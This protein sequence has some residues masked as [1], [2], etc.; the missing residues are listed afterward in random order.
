M[1]LNKA[2]TPSHSPSRWIRLALLAVLPLAL[3]LLV[4]PMLSCAATDQPSP[5]RPLGL[6]TWNPEVFQPASR[7]L[8]RTFEEKGRLIDEV[9]VPGRPPKD[10]KAPVVT[11][12]K[13]I[14]AMGVSALSFVPA[15]DWCY[16][17][18]AT[19]AA[20]LAGYYDNHGFPNMYNGPTNGG[21]CPMNNS[22]WGFG[23]CPLS[24]THMGYDGRAVR[25]HV[26]DYWRAYGNC[27]SDPYIGNWSEHA[28]GDCTGDFMGTNQSD[29]GN[30]D[31]STLFYYY[32][33][34]ARIYDYTG[35]EP[36][37]RDGCHGLRLF[38]ESRGYAVLANYSQY[39]YGY[40]GNTQGFT[41][42]DFRSEIDA[43]HPVLI[44]VAG[45]TMLGYGYNTTGNVVYIHDTWDHSDHQMTWGGTYSGLQ[46]YAVTVLQLPNVC[47]GSI[48]VRKFN[49]CDMDGAKDA[50]ESYIQGWPIRLT[51]VKA[52]GD[53]VGPFDKLT[54]AGGVA[55]FVNLDP[56]DYVVSELGNGI[57]WTKAQTTCGATSYCD[58]R[59][60]WG[61]KRWQATQPRPPDNC[62]AAA[63]APSLPVHVSCNDDV[64]VAFG[65]VELG[66]VKAF[67]FHDMNLDQMFQ[68]VGEADA[69]GDQKWTPAEQFT[70]LNCDGDWDEG[71]YFNDLNG[72]KLWDQAEL[73][74]DA[75]GDGSYDWPECPVPTWPFALTGLRADGRPICP[76][77]VTGADGWVTFPDIPPS[78]ATGYRL[79]EDD[80]ILHWCSVNLGW[81][82]DPVQRCSYT[83]TDICTGAGPCRTVDRW[84]ATTSTSRDFVL[85]CA[86]DREEQ[87][88][89]ICLSRVDGVKF[90]YDDGMPGQAD[91]V[92]RPWA[93][94]LAGKDH[95][96][97][98]IIPSASPC[99]LLP[100][101]PEAPIA[102]P[103]QNPAWY[104]TW[105]DGTDGKFRFVDLLP[106]HYHLMEQP[107]PNYR[108]A[109]SR[110][111]LS[112]FDVMCCPEEVEIQNIR[113]DLWWKVYQAHPGDSNGLDP[114]QAGHS[115]NYGDAITAV[116]G[117]L[118][119]VPGDN[120]TNYKQAAQLCRESHPKGT[121][122]IKQFGGFVQ[123]GDVF[124]P[125]A[126]RQQGTPNV[127]L[128][129]PLMYEPPT[130]TWTL[131]LLY[132][133]ETP[134]KFP[135]ESVAGYVHQDVWKWMV[136]TDIPHMKLFLD[137][138]RATPFGLDEVPLISDEVL[139]PALHANLDA[140]QTAMDAKDT[141]LA[142]LLLGQ[143]EM[144][145][146]DACLA[147]SPAR[148]VPTGPGTG[149]A[150]SV[151]NP[152]C[153]KLLVDAEYVGMMLDIFQ[154]T[155]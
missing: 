58:W 92:F 99:S 86:A 14:T 134:V 17:C 39:I 95:Y 40:K 155:K 47:V 59:T 102:I 62:N 93:I 66:E 83:V 149:I 55:Q 65:N 15:F 78:N 116:P 22:P 104:Q 6:D 26:D 111:M 24:A 126:V 5:S 32:T 38:A 71:E 127:R 154:P 115:G 21:V 34:G 85:P 36:G 152:A 28:H 79:A 8:V 144:Q 105:C 3:L 91:P 12:P 130:T 100:V 9:V 23:E 84:Q 72:N 10:F 146:M 60:T 129:W 20:M 128:H 140:V 141:V 75:D 94:C 136:D 19:S 114:H 143:F 46:H 74:T 117:V 118:E 135:G 87:F 2:A 81:P 142:G 80:S 41:Y 153:C 106:G 48:T 16:G 64:D 112:G 57:A 70:D 90:I 63:P 68:P 76:K 49:D 27:T 109:I 145:V 61:S 73:F 125:L 1:K 50:G 67:K 133:T 35:S 54:D 30:C 18:S 120:W 31:G 131:T 147:A 43:R 51:G 121:I 56:G 122:L 37:S 11:V 110:P 124:P 113:K 97:R 13:P 151:E 29:V 101:A 77:G 150:N 139:Y 33:D 42:A 82:D 137:L 53:P 69:G 119:I 88:G 52:N 7:C 123:C 132:G 98:D 103:C 4:P 148:P 44:Q 89:N 45:H 138:L 108:M 96:G 107:D 25:G